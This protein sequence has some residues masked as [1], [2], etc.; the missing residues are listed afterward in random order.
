[1]DKIRVQRLS[2]LVSKHRIVTTAFIL[3]VAVASITLANS[4]NE[5]SPVGIC[6]TRNLSG[7]ASLQGENG[8]RVGI[9]TLESNGRM[10][11]RLP[12]RPSVVLVW[13]GAALAIHQIVMADDHSPLVGG[14]AIS[15]LQP[16]AKATVALAWF[17]WCQTLPSKTSSFSGSFLV[18]LSHSSPPLRINMKNVQVARCDLPLEQST[19]SIGRFR[20]WKPAP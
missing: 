12:M 8:Y 19:L 16:H 14:T 11:C 5:I 4:R 2:G 9:L 18:S 6:S 13:H 15:V 17:N 20:L 7:S 3:I 10:P 1:M